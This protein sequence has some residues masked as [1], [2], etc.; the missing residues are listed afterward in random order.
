MAW[1]GW[2]W[3][4]QNQPKYYENMSSC[5]INVNIGRWVRIMVENF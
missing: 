1:M 3:I 2:I 5:V 4:V